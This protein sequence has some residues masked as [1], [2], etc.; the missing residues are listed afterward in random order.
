MKRRYIASDFTAWK[1]IAHVDRE[2]A[3]KERASKIAVEGHKMGQGIQ[4]YQT[5]HKSPYKRNL[6]E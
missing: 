5:S 6:S 1:A 4:L 2:A 3:K